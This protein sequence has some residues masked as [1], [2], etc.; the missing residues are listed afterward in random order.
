MTEEDLWTS[1]SRIEES[2][3]FGTVHNSW[4]IRIFMR[5]I[6]WALLHVNCL[7]VNILYYSVERT[8]GVNSLYLINVEY[9][10]GKYIKILKVLGFCKWNEL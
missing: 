2:E 4:K 9:K 10:D 6:F 8:K 3:D 1:R 7:L 5:N